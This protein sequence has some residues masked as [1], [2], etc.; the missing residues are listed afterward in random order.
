MTFILDVCFEGVSVRTVTMQLVEHLM[1][2]LPLTP[3]EIVNFGVDTETHY[4]VLQA[5]VQDACRNGEDVDDDESSGFILL[6]M[7]NV[8]VDLDR[9]CGHSVKLNALLTKYVPTYEGLVHFHTTR[10]LLL[11]RSATVAKPERGAETASRL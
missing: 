3:E 5:I 2:D 7:H 10:D 11:E 6:E 1:L 9:A 8:I 4:R